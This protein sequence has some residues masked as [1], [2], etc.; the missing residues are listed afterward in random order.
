MLEEVSAKAEGEEDPRVLA[1]QGVHRIELVLRLLDGGLQL[2]RKFGRRLRFYFH[3]RDH[4]Y[5]WKYLVKPGSGKESASEKLLLVETMPTYPEWKTLGGSVPADMVGRLHSRTR[6]KVL[7]I[8]RMLNIRQD[9]RAIIHLVGWL[10]EHGMKGESR[11][12]GLTW[13]GPE[14]V[15]RVTWSVQFDGRYMCQGNWQAKAGIGSQYSAQDLRIREQI[16]SNA[17][18]GSYAGTIQREWVDR[19]ADID[20]QLRRV[21]DLLLEQ[22]SGIRLY[23]TPKK[24]TWRFRRLDFFGHGFHLPTKQVA[25]AAEVLTSQMRANVHD[26]L[27]LIRER[28]Q[29]K[30][31]L[32][33]VAILGEVG[34][35]WRGGRWI[36]K[37]YDGGVDGL[38]WMATADRSGVVGQVYREGIGEHA[39]ENTVGEQGDSGSGE[40][41]ATGELY[42]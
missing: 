25:E 10:M 4:R 13:E 39:N 21:A 12:I 23:P 40:L 33:V 37:G 6:D 32:R 8:E 17:P 9:G 28:M 5:Q 34:W 22:H 3:K 19:L 29:V 27:A 35:E 1:V 14:Q 36:V 11:V 16:R 30:R 18:L 15:G 24:D 26:G 42:Y 38:K 7:G 41:G 20:Q 31:V 2:Q